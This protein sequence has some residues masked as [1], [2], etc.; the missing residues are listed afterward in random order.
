MG[1]DLGSVNC[2][3]WLFFVALISFPPVCGFVQ[4]VAF[5]LHDLLLS[6]LPATAHTSWF[7][8]FLLAKSD[9]QIIT[10]KVACFDPK[11]QRF[12][13]ECFTVWG[14]TNKKK[15][16]QKHKPRNLAWTCM[17]I[18]WKLHFCPHVPPHATKALLCANLFH[19]SPRVIATWTITRPFLYSWTLEVPK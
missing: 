17:K 2:T 11:L 7:G 19:L 13:C 10:D 1:L 16:L 4:K 18:F 9:V 8:S 12:W 3:P 5:H 14:C 6:F 15:T